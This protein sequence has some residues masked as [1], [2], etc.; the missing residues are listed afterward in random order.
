MS[1]DLSSDDVLEYIPVIA[2]MHRSSYRDTLMYM[3]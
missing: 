3:S 2:Q 1:R